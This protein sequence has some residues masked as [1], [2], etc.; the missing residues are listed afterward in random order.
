MFRKLNEN[1]ILLCLEFKLIILETS[2]HVSL[3]I[4]KLKQALPLSLNFN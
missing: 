2:P 1:Y 4:K 3:S